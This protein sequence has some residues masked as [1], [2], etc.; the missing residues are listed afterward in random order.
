ML[1]FKSKFFPSVNQNVCAI[2]LMQAKTKIWKCTVFPDQLDSNFSS[3]LLSCIVSEIEVE[4]CRY[5]NRVD[6][7]IK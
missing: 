1:K 7:C 4:M 3:A 5:I 6:I 2:A